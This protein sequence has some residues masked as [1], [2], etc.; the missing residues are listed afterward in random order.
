MDCTFIELSNGPSFSRSH[1]KR[2]LWLREVLPAPLEAMVL[3][4]LPKDTSACCTPGTA[5]PTV[6][7]Q[8]DQLDYS[9]TRKLKEQ[10][11]AL[12][13]LTANYT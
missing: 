1:T 3:S 13:H 10:I 6:I 5:N 12:F 11:D 9:C 2:W 8:V 7:T 4:V